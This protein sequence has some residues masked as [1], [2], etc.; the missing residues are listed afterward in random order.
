[1]LII[2]FFCSNVFLPIQ[3]HNQIFMH[4]CTRIHVND[5]RILV[6]KLIN[7]ISVLLLQKTPSIS[8]PEQKHT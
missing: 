7:F 3:K 2:F 5:Q 1:M 8:I 6:T 4:I